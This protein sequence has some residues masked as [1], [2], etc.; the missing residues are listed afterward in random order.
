MNDT[1]AWIRHGKF[2]DTELCTV[3]IQGLNLKSG[4]RICYAGT[5]IRSGY[6]VVCDSEI[7]IASMGSSPIFAQPC[8]SLR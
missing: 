2:G 3:I 6:I 8:E 7:G 5:T 1:L 4:N